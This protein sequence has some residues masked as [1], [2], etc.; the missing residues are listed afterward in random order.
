MVE[1]DEKIL[2][3]AMIREEERDKVPEWEKRME[4]L[5]AGTAS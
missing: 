5:L 2:R 3:K 4:R 1:E